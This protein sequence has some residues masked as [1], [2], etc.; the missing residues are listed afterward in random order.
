MKMK[1]TRLIVIHTGTSQ[2]QLLIKRDY[3]AFDFFNM[4]QRAAARHPHHDSQ[5]NIN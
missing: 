5:R 3:A 2:M 4:I 1:H